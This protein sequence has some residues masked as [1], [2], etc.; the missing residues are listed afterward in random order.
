M[1][2]P[3]YE[4]RVMCK[5]IRSSD[6]DLDFTFW[7]SVRDSI[8]VCGSRCG[9]DGT[10]VYITRLCKI[11]CLRI[12]FIYILTAGGM[13]FSIFSV[14]S[15][16][17]YRFFGPADQS[18]RRGLLCFRV[19]VYFRVYLCFCVCVFV[20]LNLCYIACDQKNE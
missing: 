16:V 6:I 7:E 12:K 5:V 4:I 14:L 3:T 19:C 11:K 2:P 10:L 9:G 17:W 8:I 1:L 20:I 13:D 15:V 18:S